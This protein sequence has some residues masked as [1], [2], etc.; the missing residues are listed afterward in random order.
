MVLQPEA[1]PLPILAQ[2][3][4]CNGGLPSPLQ[5]PATWGTGCGSAASLLQMLEEELGNSLPVQRR[6]GLH[7]AHSTNR[8]IRFFH[9]PS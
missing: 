1:S 4:G 8:I 9:L 5:A 7:G 6:G 3:K 2:L